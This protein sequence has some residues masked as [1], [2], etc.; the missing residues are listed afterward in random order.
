V[1]IIGDLWGGRMSTRTTVSEHEFAE[2]RENSEEAL[3]ALIVAPDA[4]TAVPL[5]ESGCVLVGR[6]AKA[7]IQIEDPL[8]S[9]NHAKLHLGELLAIEDLGSAN[10]TRV[11]DVVVPTRTPMSINLGDA[12]RIGSTVLIIQRSS[13]AAGFRRLWSHH[14][15]DDRLKD[16]CARSATSGK[17]FAL[18]R[19]LVNS[20]VPWTR[21]FP[22]LVRNLM[23]PHVLAL[24]GPNE[25]EALILEPDSETVD[26]MVKRILS[27]GKE[28]PG[29]IRIGVSWYP[30]EGRSADALL[31]KANTV[32][33]PETP[34]IATV[35]GVS[36]T[37]SAMQRVSE[38]AKRAAGVNINVLILG[39]TG[40]GK[41][42][43]ARMFHQF[44]PPKSSPLVTLNCAGLP[45]TLIEGELF[46]HE[47]GAFT[48][49]HQSS[50]GLLE[51]A[52]GGIVFLDEIGE[53]PLRIQAT[54]LRAIENR[55][56]MPL[57]GRR[58]RPIDVR[59]IAATNRDLEAEATKGTFRQDL[60]F[61]LNGISL[62][63][64]PLRERASEIADLARLFLANF[65]REC[66]R[67]EPAISAEALSLLEQYSWPG[68]IRELKNIVERAALLCDAPEILPMYLPVEQMRQ[69]RQPPRQAD[70]QSAVDQ[71]VQV[72]TPTT[73]HDLNELQRRRILEALDM[74][75]GNQS[76][77]AKWLNMP[78]RTLITKLEFF[79][80]RR[81][82]KNPPG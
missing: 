46:G 40:V 60:F 71:P 67:A 22:V 31:A 14:H 59:F 65:C 33:R 68:N 19:V 56:I 18:M 78:R 34:S 1:Y 58:S 81:P 82:Q 69:A 12:I 53:M 79:G 25:Y 3:H 70:S 64:P 16:E 72:L 7:D 15:F 74:F 77:A 63:I 10:G 55:E 41:E 52:E 13:W 80:I 36:S 38:A 32:I 47:K 42:V 9:R 17:R 5:P 23:P 76:R 8:A 35:P 48:G 6:T 66:G 28:V 39:E 75:A 51:S 54:L 49:A 29:S 50:K 27:E 30:R 26:Q 43:M 11:H 73:P 62:V 45:E 2:A 37:S 21:V 61:R 20:D 4:F 44:S 24:Y 57:G